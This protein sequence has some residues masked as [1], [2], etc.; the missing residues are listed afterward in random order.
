MTCSTLRFADLIHSI[1]YV[2][3][4]AFDER[5]ESY[6]VVSMKLDLSMTK[7][8]LDRCCFVKFVQTNASRNRCP[9]CG[10]ECFAN[11]TLHLCSI[12]VSFT[13]VRCIEELKVELASWICQ[14]ATTPAGF[15]LIGESVVLAES[16]TRLIFHLPT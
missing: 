14:E 2:Y 16:S 5:N 13:S 8:E 12:I 3:V 6:V 10:Y 11:F 7:A 9:L 4:K 15:S 1:K